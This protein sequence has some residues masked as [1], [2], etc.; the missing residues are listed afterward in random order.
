VTVAVV[1]LALVAADGGAYLALRSFLI[2]Q[3]EQD[4]ETAA[5]QTIKPLFDPNPSEIVALAIAN[6]APPSVAVEAYDANGQLVGMSPA[7]GIDK[8]ALPG[9]VLPE[10]SAVPLLGRAGEADKLPLAAVNG[11]ATA[12][13][14]SGGFDY[15]LAGIDA[16]DGSIAVVALPML[17]GAATLGRLALIELAVTLSV[18]VVVAVIAT[19]L[20]A[21]GLRPLAGIEATAARIASG[22]LGSRVRTVNPGTEVGRLGLALN[23]MLGRIEGA[24]AAHEASEQRLRRLVTDAS[25][26]LRTP[27]T[28]IRGYAELFRRGAAARPADLAR[29]MRGIEFESERLGSLVDDLLLLARLDE[30]QLMPAG[31]EDLVAVVRAAVDAAQAVEPDRPIEIDVPPS[32]SVRVDPGRLRQVVDNLLA[33]VRVHTPRGTAA[34]VTIREDAGRISL[35]VADRGPGMSEVARS[36]AFERFFRADPSRSRDSGGSGLGLSIVAAIAH[37]YGGDCR[38]ESEP[39]QGTRFI[40]AWPAVATLETERANR[41]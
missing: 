3:A 38:V 19:R 33:N 13:A 11:T 30:D 7:R 5:N 4:L 18:L 21:I 1:A 39:G 16:K 15:V 14:T 32:A 25:H 6:G 27:L 28:S 26:E 2:A 41:V 37:A 20:V 17:E 8:A 23:T 29:A 24:M 22:E 12:A 36:R 34:T 10:L 9:P 40:V 31:E 35:E